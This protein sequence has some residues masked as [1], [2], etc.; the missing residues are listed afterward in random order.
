MAGGWFVFTVNNTR[1]VVLSLFQVAVL[2]SPHSHR[3]EKAFTVNWK[4]SMS[5]R[6]I[7]TDL[8]GFVTLDTFYLVGEGPEVAP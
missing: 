3:P 1:W 2:R 5:H 7:F 8:A 4:W 6:L